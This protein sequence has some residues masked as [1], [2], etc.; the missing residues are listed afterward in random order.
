[1]EWGSSRVCQAEL[2]EA[3]QLVPSDLQA[4]DNLVD[5]CSNKT[6]A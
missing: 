6:F 2:P 4:A 5:T 3:L 1:M